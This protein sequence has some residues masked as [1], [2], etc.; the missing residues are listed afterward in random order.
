MDKREIRFD[1]WHVDFASGEISK[2]G[3]TQRLQDQPLQ[4]LD[5]LTRAPGEVVTRE[6]LIARLWPKGVVEFDTGLNTAIRKLRSALGDDA[7]TPRYIATLPRKGYRFVAQLTPAPA[8]PPVAAPTP[9]SLA[10]G[11]ASLNRRASDRRAPLKRLA[12]GFGSLAAALILA[13]VAWNMPGKLFQSDAAHDALP[14]IVVLPLVDMSIDQNEQS[15]CDGLTEELSN[16]LAHIPTLRVVARTSAFAFKG[17]NTDV[18]GIAKQLEASHVLEGSLRRSGDQLRITTQLI[19]ASTGLHIWSKSFD[20]PLGDIFMIEDTVSRSVAEALHLELSSDTAEQWAQRQP[21]RM[22]AYELYLLGKARQRKRTAEDNIKATEFLR[23]AVETDPEFA[24]AQVGLAE[25]LLNSLSLNRAPLEDVAAEV[26]PLINRALAI[27]PDLPDAL[28]AKGWLYTEEYKLAEAKVLLEKAI[29]GNPND[30]SSLRFLGNLYDRRAQ[31]N[32]ALANY[33][34]AAKLDPLDFIG[35]VFRCQELVDLADFEA[36]DAACKRA[37]E[38]DASNMWGPLTTA[39]IARARGRTEEALQ[40][41]EAARKL[42]P[43]DT[44]LADQKIDLLLTLRRPD[45][46]NA[47]RLELPQDNSFFSLAREGAIVSARG[48]PQALR[49]WMAGNH[50][51][52]RAGTGAE[53]TE[54]AR[55]QMVAG[56]LLAARKTL[57]HADRIL[58][59]L[60]GD[61]YDGSQI[62][63]EYSGALI[64]ARI[65][66]NGGGDRARALQMLTDFERMLDTYEKSGGRH[67]GLYTLRAESFALRGDKAK[68]QQALQTAWKHGW[69]ATWKPANDPLFA[70]IELPKGE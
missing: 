47:V 27:S 70:G 40:W 13:V 49:Q 41:V 33:S 55:M 44:W 36:A 50:I 26:E 3:R 25:T 24:L 31:P 60:S 61:L 22:E 7:E 57:L 14:T 15:L 58:P 20:L 17:K 19:E 69:R 10:E 2:D 68:A 9:Q 12:W 1:G 16:W 62:R 18:R 59:I 8:P 28:A 65:E 6:T 4:I 46:A 43:N 54:L 35:H 56:D 34:A 63:H 30:A 21:A 53:L 32:E 23:R 52:T 39:W 51:E 64:R 48:G 11:P 37:R 42:A 29:E 66:L 38:L 45:D 5:E 67:F